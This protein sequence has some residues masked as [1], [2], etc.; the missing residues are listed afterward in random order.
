[1]TTNTLAAAKRQKKNNNQ[2]KTRGLDGGEARYEAQPAGGV[3]AR[4]VFFFAKFTAI[5][6]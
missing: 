2:P 5:Y 3:V 1:M 4:L 6:A